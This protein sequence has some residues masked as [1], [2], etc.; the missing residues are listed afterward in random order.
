MAK[1]I[2]IQGTASNVGKSLIVAGLCR[3]FK[4]DGRRVAPFKSQNMALNSF[5]TRS[6][7]EMGRAQV[8]QAEAAGIEPDADMNPILLKPSS[9]TTSQ[10]IVQGEIF[11]EE[12][13]EAYYKHKRA[14]E[15]KIRESFERLSAAYDII[16]LEGAGSPVEI[17]LREQDIV[18]MY[19]ARLARAPV[20]LAG[21][22][23]RGGVFA[24]LV[25][26]MTLFTGEDRRLVRGVL[27]NKFRGDEAILEPG[28]R[29]L[30]DLIHRPVLGVIPY[31]RLDIDD[32]DSLSER[33]HAPASG[34]R[35]RMARDTILADIAVIRFSRISN[36]TDFNA[37]S[38]LPGVLL[39]YVDSPEA[40]GFPDMVILPGTKNTMADLRRLRRSGLEER[41]R[42]LA[43]RGTPVFGIC[44]GY[45]MLGR[46]LAD[47]DHVEEGGEM[48]GLGLLPVA[49]VFEKEKV[50]TRVRGR[51]GALG[52]VLRPLSGMELEGYEVHMGS[53]LRISLRNS[54]PSGAGADCSPLGTIRNINAADAADVADGAFRGNVYGTYVHGIF[55]ADGIASAL[56]KALCAAKGLDAPQGAPPDEAAPL[57]LKAYKE[58]QYDILA[59][60]LRD[61]IDMNRIYRILEEGI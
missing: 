43:G 4:Q 52:G 36:F 61:H 16:V 10:V 37:L 27:I 48:E 44:G 34:G 41:I 13:A 55:D 56:V 24:S 8:V 53:S 11:A 42:G 58:K 49:T 20:I 47:P 23:D 17:N 25:G 31:M 39:R 7:L 50:R 9:D 5:I 22:I 38:R 32:E 29:Q 1:T 6:G 30:E 18:N 12:N 46:T 28:L 57:G 3:I 40:L 21:D 14:L 45:Q 19:M 35:D 26:T 51:F 60:T 59:A 54:R 2:M 15:P 33:F